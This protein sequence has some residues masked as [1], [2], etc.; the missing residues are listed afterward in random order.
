M[1]RALALEYLPVTPAIGLAY[2]WLAGPRIR[3]DHDAVVAAI[4]ESDV[5]ASISCQEPIRADQLSFMI[6]RQIRAEDK[7]QLTDDILVAAYQQE[8]SV[9][10]AAAFLSERTG[11]TVTKNKIQSALRRSGVILAV[12][13]SKKIAENSNLRAES[14]G[15]R[16]GL[17]L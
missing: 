16:D 3:V 15:R 8:G 12:I 9:R 13:S 1:P 5:T 10:K 14:L 2:Q 7:T 6:R 11:Q 4:L 17:A